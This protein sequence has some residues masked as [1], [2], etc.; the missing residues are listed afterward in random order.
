MTATDASTM[1]SA[2][3]EP[4][5]PDRPADALER[6]LLARWDEE[7]LFEQT[8]SANAEAPSFVFFEG[9]P[10][11]NGRP[12]IH[13]VFA[14]TIK[15]LFCRHRAMKGFRVLR[16][17]GW[18]THGLPVEIEV[19]KQLGI[20][21]KQQ[22]DALG[23]A[24]FN[25]LCR[26][27]VFRYR[28]DWEK[29]SARMAYWLDYEH[30]YVT[31]THD[32]V[33]SV[34]W[35]LKT[36]FDKDLLYRGHKILPYCPR[37]GTALSSH[38]VAQGY[39]EVEDP[40]VYV[41]LELVGDEGDNRSLVADAPR[42]DG[43]SLVGRRILVWTTTPWTLV[44]NTALAVNPDLEY[45]EVIR[46][47]GKDYRT[48]ILAA[49][50]LRPVLGDDFE[51]RWEIIRRLSGSE[52]V[53]W[54]YRR[55]FDWLEYPEGRAHEIVVGESF[56]S[57]EDGSGVVHM[58]P[59][60]GGDDYAAGQRHNLAFLQP[61]DARGQ[62]PRDLPVV[63]GLF[64]KDADALLIEELKRR[65][66]LWKAARIMHSYPHCW[67]CDTPLL[68]YART[69]W[70]VRTTAYRDSMLVRNAA[71]DWHPPEAGEGRFGEWLKNNIDWAISRDRYWGTPL[72]VWLCDADET[73]VAVV[74]SYAE[75]SER[76]GSAL[77]N[78]FDPHK[79]QVDSYY[80]RCTKAG[81]PG[82]MRRV[83][84]V[85][86]T[87]FDSGSMPFAQWHYPFE[88]RDRLTAQYPADFIA[89]VVDQTRG[90]FY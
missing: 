48:F 41:A 81:C 29:L 77:P 37:C 69:S 56:V 20:S 16:K 73:H 79:P 34:W 83:P 62:F 13:H 84:E 57:A 46:R 76:V 89:E 90:W 1:Q 35:S 32:Y 82:H 36:L 5:P 67:R 31:Y 2:R 14:R 75:F 45:V 87:W 86:D 55:P 11:A 70:F 7:R 78:D 44:S 54:R 59:A 85:I 88:N 4:L 38:E 74:G 6:E 72:P 58:S 26:E 22:I 61:V 3:F 24:E 39:E 27:S 71:V 23:V 53:G 33:E 18:D 80:W 28:T 64:V 40:S 68:N 50:R 51:N 52:M 21:G 43:S 42:D 15:D 65:G 66:V 8:I 17:A 9:P 10:T 19:E 25:R 63:G 30:P 60:F 47:E 49:D 12:G